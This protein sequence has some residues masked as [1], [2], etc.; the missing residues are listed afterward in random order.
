M[1]LVS[2]PLGEYR[3]KIVDDGI[4]RNSEWQERAARPRSNSCS[5][6][7]NVA[8]LLS[9]TGVLNVFDLCSS[10]SSEMSHN[11][12]LTTSILRSSLPVLR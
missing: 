11:G 9:C 4:G 10:M 12:S 2:R 3:A 8:D 5:D 6:S 7:V 1:R